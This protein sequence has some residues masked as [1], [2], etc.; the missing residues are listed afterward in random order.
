MGTIE[1]LGTTIGELG[2]TNS[3]FEKRKTAKPELSE[4]NQAI[5]KKFR[6]EL[7][8][9][10]YSQKT[11][12]MYE[13]Y[14]EMFLQF[15][16]KPA[17]EAQREDIISFMAEMKEKRQTSN[18]TIAL[19]LSALKY[20]YHTLLHLK[21]I[22]EIKTPKKAKKLPI[23]LTKEE[24]KLLFKATKA[25]RNRL[26]LEFLYSTG[27]RVSEASKLKTEDLELEEGIARVKGGKGNKDR[28]IILSKQWISE[29]KKYLKK[30][31][32]K[33]AFVFSKKNATPISTD[34]IERMIKESAAKAKITKDITPHKLRHSFATH[35][36]ESGENIRKIQ[37]LL[38]H[39]NLSTTQ[40]YTQVTTDELKKVVSPFDTMQKKKIIEKEAIKEQS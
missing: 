9:A 25:G 39:S 22:E 40:I 35:L 2:T 8:V 21:I 18:S 37:E 23:T 36:L 12:T 26:I 31:K 6:Q 11:L 24:L 32:N 7:L 38:G 30:K 17:K 4:E 3:E 5:V 1:E 27:C 15:F 33:S 20:F 19:A 10:G 28:I 14:V 16:K 29:I 13:L 34:T